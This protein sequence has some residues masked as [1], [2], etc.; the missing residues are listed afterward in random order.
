MVCVVLVLVCS[1]CNDTIPFR[2]G[3]GMD[4]VG[5]V[6]YNGTFRVSLIKNGRAYSNLFRILPWEANIPEFPSISRDLQ[7]FWDIW[8]DFLLKEGLYAFLRRR[9][10][11]KV[12]VPTLMSPKS[13]S[14][15]KAPHQS[16]SHPL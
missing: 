12:L 11:S 3:F 5:T 7:R 1:Y 10:Y 6:E 9:T 4:I 13:A 8:I 16:I 2:L 14:G 15:G